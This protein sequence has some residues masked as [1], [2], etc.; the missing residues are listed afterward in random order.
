MTGEV[1]MD[2][3]RERLS[4]RYDR[5]GTRGS[6][7]DR[8]SSD[9]RYEN[10]RYES[11]RY[12]RPERPERS[13][14][15]ERPARRSAPEGVSHEAI[16]DTLND[17]ISKS[18]R[19]QL[20]VIADFFDEAKAD[21]MESERAVIDAISHGMSELSS[22]MGKAAAREEKPATPIA[23]VDEQNAETLSRIERIAGQNAETL[24]E[25]GEI[26]ERNVDSLRANSEVL[27][28]IKNTVG[29]ILMSSEEVRNASG[30]LQDSIRQSMGQMM[31]A[32]APAQDLTVDFSEEK[33]EI[34]NAVG[35]NRAILNMI[36]QDVLN[37]FA[38]NGEPDEEDGGRVVPFSAEDADK[39]YKELE[40]H[41][42]KECVKCY[43]NVQ[44][45]LTEQ[46]A[47]TSAGI[48]KTVSGMKLFVLLSFIFDIVTLLLV[49]AVLLV[50]MGIIPSF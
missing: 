26:L 8:A 1:K 5:S 3:F 16:S 37:G 48:I 13:D 15:M 46:N 42:H 4:G 24:N 19:E 20:D 27:N 11:D 45:T 44:Q 12:D 10:D 41:V 31:V 2:G 32:A 9:D 47:Q 36:R 23:V 18:N 34:I 21:R 29:Q 43:R 22:N 50:S 7:Y 33:N 40:D 49:A 30:Q 38:R 14:R 39:Y 25:N 35:D 6:G 28:E 17:V